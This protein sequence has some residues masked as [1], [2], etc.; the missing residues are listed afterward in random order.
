MLNIFLGA[1]NRRFFSS[2]F[3]GNKFFILNLVFCLILNLLNWLIAYIKYSLVSGHIALH[4]NIYF[5]VDYFGSPFSIF[6]MPLAGLIILLINFIL[7]Y[8]VIARTK[9]LSY[10]L[11]GISSFYQ[12]LLFIATILVVNLK[13]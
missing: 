12:V 8:F 11:I 1:I 9:L 2:L 4:Y 7:A 6:I 5:G 13:T 3:F 10:L